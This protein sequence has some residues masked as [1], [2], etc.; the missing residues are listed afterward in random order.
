MNIVLNLIY[1]YK[2]SIFI[3]KTI[4]V[5]VS[6]TVRPICIHITFLLKKKIEFYIDNFFD[7]VEVNKFH[8][9]FVTIYKKICIM[10]V[11][12]YFYIF[13]IKQLLI[14]QYFNLT[15][16]ILTTRLISAREVYTYMINGL[17]GATAE[18]ASFFSCDDV[19][20]LA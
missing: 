1:I 10:Y 15:L 6:L 11:N 4:I 3:K 9:T 2:K 12:I 5:L 17:H 19:T 20:Y 13:I 8:Q 16:Y 14:I 18:T 7:N